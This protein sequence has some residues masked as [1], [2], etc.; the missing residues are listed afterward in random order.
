MLRS[1]SI[2]NQVSSKSFQAW[3]FPFLTFVSRYCGSV[4]LLKHFVRYSFVMRLVCWEKPAGFSY[5]LTLIRCEYLLRL[6]FLTLFIYI[7]FIIPGILSAPFF[8]IS[9]WASWN[10]WVS[11]GHQIFLAS[12]WNIFHFFTILNHN[13]S[14]PIRITRAISLVAFP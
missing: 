1:S 13:Y 5:S 9:F 8:F 2:N 6:F 12:I 11:I 4:V 14:K 3:L 7:S 10:S